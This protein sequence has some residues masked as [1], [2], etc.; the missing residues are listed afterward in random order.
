MKLD[1]KF[2][3]VLVIIL[4]LSRII[5]HIFIAREN[6]INFYKKEIHSVIIKAQDQGRSM[7]YYLRDGTC[8]NFIHYY[9]DKFK[10][11]DSI[12]K[13]SNSNILHVFKSTGMKYEY[14]F[15]FDYTRR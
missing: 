1:N 4:I 10:V 5:Y 3:N 9:D 12:N 7:D 6:K 14:S 13:D 15:K 8:L 2:L 11:S